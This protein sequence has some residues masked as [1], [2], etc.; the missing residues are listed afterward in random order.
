M[1]IEL[2]R[3]YPEFLRYHGLA[4]LQQARCN[5][6]TDPHLGSGVG[7]DLMERVT[8]YDVVERK[9]AGFSQVVNDCFYGWTQ[10]HPYW[11]SMR[12]GKHTR[13]REFTAR[14]WTGK[15]QDFKLPEWL[16][17][18]ILHRVCGSG[19][20]YARQP[21]G[22]HNTLLTELHTARS[23]EDMVGIVRTYPGPFYTSIGYQF[24]SFPKPPP[25]YKRGGDWYLSEYAPRLAR[26][27]AEFLA[28]GGQRELREVGAFM[29]EWNSSNGLRQYKFQYS[30]VVADVADWYPYYVDRSSPFYYGS[31]AV[32]CINYLA[33]P[34]S[35]KRN[36]AFLDAVM[37][38]AAADTG[39]YPYNL[40]D[41]CC[42]FIRWAEN[43][44]RP[45]GAYDHLDFD[46]VWGSCAIADHPFGRQRAMLQLGLVD[47]FNGM[48]YHPSDDAVLRQAG[49]TVDEYKRMVAG[50]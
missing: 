13:E 31:N 14:A 41:V 16:Y 6:G 1:P 25:G 37:E 49:V 7:D 32:E 33:D 46:S 47:T 30:A 4:K 12:A 26:D 21:S 20:N 24:P 34:R 18:F 11:D 23:I 35:G 17:V 29:L 10:W 3:Y 19:I 45:G 28:S 38:R 9:Y 27:L 42:D 39:G 15:H 8:L 22:Y 43:Y 40:E 5:L 48:S 44:V 50:L 36:E 2:T